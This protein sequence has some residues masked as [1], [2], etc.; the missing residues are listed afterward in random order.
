M[1]LGERIYQYRTQRN[2]SQ[3]DL[4]DAL[5]VS[6]QS[7]SKWENNSAVPEL[8]K[9]LKIAQ[10]FGITID[11]L[12]TGKETKPPVPPAQPAMAA[13]KVQEPFPTRKILGIILLTCGLLAFIVLFAVG[14]FTGTY[15]WGFIIGLPLI[16]IGTLCL[17][18]KKHLLLICGWMLFVPLWFIAFILLI[19]SPGTVSG[20][21]VLFVTAFGAILSA[22]TLVQ[23]WTGKIQMPFV[24]KIIITAFIGFMLLM[25]VLGLLPPKN[26]LVEL[27]P[28]HY[29]VVNTM[30]TD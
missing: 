2:M 18:V 14:F 27:T 9:L 20:F 30:D 23:L 24:G 1:N 22:V 11:E 13:Q 25:S 3:G 6:R 5:E 26:G 29:V 4:A 10:L 21:A 28:E 17:L 15:A 12:V 16:I 19:P 7:V 8:E